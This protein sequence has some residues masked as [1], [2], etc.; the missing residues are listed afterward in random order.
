[1]H[2]YCDATDTFHLNGNGHA[3]LPKWSGYEPCRDGFNA[4]QRALADLPS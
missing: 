1:M 2:G 4:D 3:H